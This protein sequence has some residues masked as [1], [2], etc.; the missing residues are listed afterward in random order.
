MAAETALQAEALARELGTLVRD[1]GVRE[2]RPRVQEAR[3]QGASSRA[4]ST[5]RW[6]RWGS[7]AAASR[8]GW[9]ATAPGFRALAAVAE[10]LAW[11]YPP[12]S[13]PMNLQAATV[14]LT[15]ANWGTPE[16]VDRYVPGLVSAELLGCNAMT[17]PDGGSDF[18]GAMR[19]R[20]VR[21]GDDYVHQRRQDVDHQCQRRRRRDGLRQDRS[22]GRAQ[23]RLGLPG[24][25]RDPGLRGH[26]RAVPGA[27]QAHADQLGGPHRR[28][29]AGGARAGRGG[30]GLRRRHER[31]GLRPPVGRRPLGR[32]WP[33]PAWTRRWTTPTSGWP[34]GRRSASS[35]WSRSSSPT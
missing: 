20:A 2:V 3:G 25:D 31:D 29:R 17:E 7:S 18:L 4:T 24:A 14:P 35:R 32:A 27:G 28:P 5:A 13:A 8:S 33:R 21:D 1:W 22:G 23:G 19:T 34:S 15:I 11:V 6:A 12:L 30:S 10:N 26:A 16:L 9:A